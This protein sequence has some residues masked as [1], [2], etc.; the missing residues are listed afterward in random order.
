MIRQVVRGL[1]ALVAGTILIDSAVGQ[2]QPSTANTPDKIVVRDK[3]DGSTKTYE[4]NLKFGPGGYQI[5]SADKKVLA[6][7]APGDIVKHTPGEMVGLDRGLVMAQISLEDKKTKKEY[8]TAR[9]GYADLLKK[10][11]KAD[12][13]GKRYL[14]YKIALM[15]TKVADESADDEGWAALADVAVKA[16]TGFLGEYKT[17]WEVWPATKTQARLLAELNNYD[18]VARTWSRTGKAPDLPAD[19]K[20]EA[21]LQEID[22]LIRSGKAFSNARAAA[23]TLGK[24][25][26]PGVTKDKLA[27]YEITAKAADDSDYAAGIKKIE[28]AIAASKDPG[29]RGVGY[30]MIGELHLIAKKPRDAMWAFLWVETVYNADREDAFKALCR[31]AEVFKAQGDD[32]RAKTY[33]EKVRRARANF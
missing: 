1:V 3:K 6:T 33:R 26:P 18:E 23:E 15:S 9:V 14:E 19:L 20:L 32:D 2:G 27:I 5:V 12:E 16:W 21:G 28:D 25:A 8:E 11:P 30:G 4:G 7:V 29:V 10:S 24:A 22:A 13:G 31:L 17:S